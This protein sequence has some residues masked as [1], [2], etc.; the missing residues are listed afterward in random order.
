MTWRQALEATILI[1][2]KRAKKV[3]YTNEVCPMCKRSND[4][5]SCRK[6]PAYAICNGKAFG[7]WQIN[8]TRKNAGRVLRELIKLR[9][10]KKCMGRT[11]GK[12][13]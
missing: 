5:S 1:W 9:K 6:C 8:D 11:K 3:N 4:V 7:D 12:K 2:Q 10:H 13:D